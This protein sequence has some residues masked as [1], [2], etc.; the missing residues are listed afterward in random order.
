MT[1]VNVRGKLIRKRREEKGLSLLDV[2]IKI[3]KSESYMSRIENGKINLTE[4]YELMIVIILWDYLEH[5]QNEYA[6]L[7]RKEGLDKKFLYLK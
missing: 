3:G 5:Y 6:T 4:Q 7:F 1:G 2:A